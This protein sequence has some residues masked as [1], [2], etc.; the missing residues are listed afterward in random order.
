MPEA[1]PVTIATFPL[2]RS[3]MREP[4]GDRCDSRIASNDVSR[5]D[6]GVIDQIEKGGTPSG[7]L[8]RITAAGWSAEVYGNDGDRSLSINLIYFC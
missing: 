6:Q 8:R 4:Q 7:D 2:K 1:A 3:F 5:L